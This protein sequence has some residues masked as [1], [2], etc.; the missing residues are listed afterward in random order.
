M[1]GRTSASSDDGGGIPVDQAAKPEPRD[2]H[3]TSIKCRSHRDTP[4][5]PSSTRSRRPGHGNGRA[6]QNRNG[7][8]VERVPQSSEPQTHNHYLK[9]SPSP[10]PTPDKPRT[11][12]GPWYTTIL[13]LVVSMLGLALLAL[14]LYSLA[15]RQLDPKGCRM[16]YMRPSY[17]KF[18]DFDTE[19]TRFATKY[20]LF[21]Y[22]E[23]DTADEK[24]HMHTGS[25][26][27]P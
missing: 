12:R 6:P 10:D 13:T 7:L 25:P 19:H 3:V 17:V 22:R 18:N 15:T 27:P 1:N 4:L 11:R 20:S 26:S 8:V 5:S 16:S 23:Q 2:D 14:I 9:V 21:L 24:V